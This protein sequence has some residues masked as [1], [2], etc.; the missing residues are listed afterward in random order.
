[1][2]VQVI[3][4]PV[5]VAV[6]AAVVVVVVVVAAAYLLIRYTREGCYPRAR[7]CRPQPE[8]MH[9]LFACTWECKDCRSR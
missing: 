7:A 4:V 8:R 3:V 1:M 5:V 9:V 2:V 6:A